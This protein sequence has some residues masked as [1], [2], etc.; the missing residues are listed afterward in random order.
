MK[1]IDLDTLPEIQKLACCYATACIETQ[2]E[3]EPTL[4]YWK[5]TEKLAVMPVG[6]IFD[7]RAAVMD[8]I[9]Q[10]LQRSPT[11]CMLS[12]AWTIQWKCQLRPQRLSR[13]NCPSRLHAQ[14]A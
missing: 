13:Q 14:T 11:V 3:I 6:F 4:V 10:L 7:N 8:I 12:E 2:A 1:E 9:K 5:G